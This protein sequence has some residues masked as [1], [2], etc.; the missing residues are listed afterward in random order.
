V[1]L[2]DDDGRA[3]RDRERFCDVVGR[4]VLEHV[5]D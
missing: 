4:D 5:V 3:D 2:S 1:A